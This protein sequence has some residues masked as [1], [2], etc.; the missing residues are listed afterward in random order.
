[1][2]G[3]GVGSVSA[4]RLW[5]RGFATPRASL[6]LSPGA[7]GGGVG[8][9]KGAGLPGSP[10]TSRPAPPPHALRAK[11]QEWK[12][13]ARLWGFTNRPRGLARLKEHLPLAQAFAAGV[14]VGVGDR[15]HS[16]EPADFLSPCLGHCLPLAGPRLALFPETSL[17]LS[18]C[19]S[20][21]RWPLSLS[22]P[23]V[24]SFSAC[25]GGHHGQEAAHH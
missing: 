23:A 3:L 25:L 16:L 21:A 7:G 10:R 9:G 18:S 24:A 22:F 8:A 4:R 11:G 14:P 15:R 17:S 12:A 6:A 19:P 20:R 13:P 5:E 1:M 2:P